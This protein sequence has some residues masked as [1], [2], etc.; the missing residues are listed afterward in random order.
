M[1]SKRPALWLLG[2]CSLAIGS[3]G[4]RE[5]P[6]SPP[7][8]SGVDATLTEG[9]THDAPSGAEAGFETGAAREASVGDG[10]ASDGTAP[11]GKA[12][13]AMP[14]DGKLSADALLSYCQNATSISLNAA[15]L[16][17]ATGDILGTETA[18]VVNL[19]SSGCT[20]KSTPGAES[21][22]SA[23]LTA[24]SKY[25]IRVEPGSGYNPSLYVFKSCLDVAGTCAAGVEEQ[26][27]GYGEQIKF[28]PPTSG[29][30]FFGVD[31]PH[32][33][34]S[35]FSYGSFEITLQ[36]YTPPANDSCS[37]ATEISLSA[38]TGSVADG[39]TTY[40]T[41]DVTLAA[42]GCT[43]AVTKGP[44]V[45]YA[46]PAI[47]GRNYKVTL[48]PAS[49]YNGSLYVFTSCSAVST[50]CI[51]GSDSGYSGQ[52]EVVTFEAK[53]SADHFIG[54][55]SSYPDGTSYGSGKFTLEIE[56][57][58]PASNLSCKSP[59][60]LSFSSGGKAK[61][62]GDTSYSA[63]EFSGLLTCGGYTAFKGP[64]LYYQASLTANSTY[65]VRVDPASSLD[66][67][68]Y[69]FRASTSCTSTAI[70]AACASTFTDSASIGKPE[71]LVL[72]PKTSEDWIFV[73]DSSSTS[74]SGSFTLTVEESTTPANDTCASAET[75][76]FG[77][78]TSVSVSA[79]TLGAK[80]DVSLAT[81]DCT[82]NTTA[83][84]DVFYAL[85]LIAGKTYTFE[86]DGIGSWDEV[87]YLF[88]SCSSIASTCGAK[89]GA[90]D[91][92]TSPETIT[93]TPPTTG[94][95]Y[96]GVDGKASTDEGIFTLTVKEK[97]TPTN[98]PCTSAQ[99]LTWASGGV[100]VVGD[101]TYANDDINL[102]SAG[103]TGYSSSGFD[104]F[105]SVTL[106][107]GVYLVTLTPGVAFDAMLYVFTS[108]SSPEATCLKGSDDIGSGTPET[109]TLAP[110]TQ[111]TYII[112]VDSYAASDYGPFTLEVK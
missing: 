86:L 80:N 45:F 2:I 40:A 7:K 85:P 56:E 90:D 69:A 51:G 34:G 21:F 32:T 75:L 13:D 54:V 71:V 8:D 67:V 31:S 23:S 48:K 103:C 37:G 36:E 27:A 110:T 60:T 104:V 43:G 59:E 102:T 5:E 98:D 15:G 19:T 64:Q 35:S 6:A 47:S 73:V 1:N 12:G 70:N 105:Y 44:D 94:T 24:G 25:V 99:T 55:G 88:T 93:Y 58:T 53:T 107:P 46:F 62:T 3:S 91:W 101:T 61:T 68:L 108:C 72:S 65:L 87:L 96:I 84:P 20:G 26:Y 52:T 77:S 92:F 29:T 78:S 100:K 97:V 95:Y 66:P 18:S 74:S 82:G 39:D 33:A 111:T 76:S 81:T 41:H 38:G 79:H 4:C 49:G 112:G 22:F 28:S 14:G 11:D 57:Y 106:S 16:G 9:G 30:Y 50:S 109:I 89:M 42:T 63:E 83:G 17:T 10:K